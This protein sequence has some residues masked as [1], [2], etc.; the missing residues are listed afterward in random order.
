MR[1]MSQVICIVL[2]ALLC[3]EQ[4]FCAPDAVRPVV[5]YRGEIKDGAYNGNVHKGVEHFKSVTGERCEEM[6]ISLPIVRYEEAVRTMAKTGYSPIVIPYSDAVAS[7]EAIALDFPGTRFVLLDGQYDLP[8]IYCFTFDEHEGAFLAGALAAMSSRTGVLGFVG[9]ADLP[10]I[11]RFLCG[12]KQGARYENPEVRIVEN[13]LGN[14]ENAWHDSGA[15]T[16]VTRSQI[17]SGADVIFQVAGQAGLAVLHEVAKSGKLSIGVD[18]NQNGVAPGSVLSSLVKRSDKAVF[19]A[20][21]IAYRGGWRE[22]QRRL[23]LS[24]HVIYLAFDH[25][26]ES[27]VPRNSLVEIERVIEQIQLGNISVHDFVDNNYCPVW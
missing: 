1:I 17:N 11:N 20:L 15:A 7:M 2:L 8:N 5:L 21:M 23:G 14:D 19:A 18:Q 24:Q 3:T 9:G 16:R 27:L 12:F 25:Y 26:N 6:Q 10:V 4:A 22:N 13:F